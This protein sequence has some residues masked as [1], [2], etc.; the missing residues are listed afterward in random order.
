MERH[1]LMIDD[2]EDEYNFFKLGLEDMP[3][4][5]CSYAGNARIGMELLASGLYD[6]VLI[7]MNMSLVNGMECLKRIKADD[8]ICNI[9]AFIY[10]TGNTEELSNEAAK[11][12][13]IDCY[14]KPYSLGELKNVIKKMLL[15]SELQAVRFRHRQGKGNVH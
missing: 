3:G 12:G 13:A 15:L 2:D 5:K 7:D 4:V 11:S 8:T 6:L 14:K 1:I 9:P 10:T